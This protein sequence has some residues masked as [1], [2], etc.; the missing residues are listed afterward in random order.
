MI[1][2]RPRTRLAICFLR[3]SI[4]RANANSTP[5]PRCNPPP[6]NSSA[7]SIYW[8][9]NCERVEG[10][11][12]TPIWPSWMR[13]GMRSRG[14]EFASGSR[15]AILPVPDADPDQLPA[16]DL[17]SGR[18]SDVAGHFDAASKER[19]TGRGLWRWRDRKYFRRANHQCAGQVYRLVG[20]DLL[21]PHLH[22]VDLVCA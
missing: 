2:N 21:R 3:S 10:N 1:E 5:R 20:R 19:R 4:W 16:R 15:L 11:W 14:S 7:D 12:A 18:A 8:K 13:S 17:R 6:T 22:F 9:M